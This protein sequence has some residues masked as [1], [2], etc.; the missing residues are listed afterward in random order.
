MTTK[1]K[2]VTDES[3]EILD[4]VADGTDI[5]EPEVKED[6]VVGTQ[7]GERTWFAGRTPTGKGIQY[8]RS[9][10]SGNYV[11]EF[12]EGGELPAKLTGEWTQPRFAQDAINDYLN[13][14][15]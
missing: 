6:P 3:L 11:I 8:K 5:P 14:R 10:T 15:V 7:I 12:M 1:R 4:A 2:P 13:Q 9:K